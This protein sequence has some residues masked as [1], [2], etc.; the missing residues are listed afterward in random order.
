MGTGTEGA[1]TATSAAAATTSGTGMVVAKGIGADTG[2]NDG[3][4]AGAATAAIIVGAGGGT[5]ATGG[6]TAFFS[7]SMTGLNS[8]AASSY[9]K[10]FL[11]STR[12]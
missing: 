5:A 11:A 2:E 10:S 4:K 8:P 1:T 3:K 12:W 9:T 7:R 6:A